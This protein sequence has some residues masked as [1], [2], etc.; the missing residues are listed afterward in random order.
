MVAEIFG[1]RR[2]CGRRR[3]SSRRRGRHALHGHWRRRDRCCAG[4]PGCRGRTHAASD[5]HAAQKDDNRNNG[6]RHEQE[7]Q[8]LPA[9]LNLVELVLDV[10]ERF[11]HVTLDGNTRVPEAGLKGCA[12][13]V[14]GGALRRARRAR[15]ACPRSRSTRSGHRWPRVRARS[16]GGSVLRGIAPGPDTATGRS[17]SGVRPAL[18]CPPFFVEPSST[19]EVKRRQL[20]LVAF[21]GR[22]DRRF[23]A[24]R[25]GQV[26]R[27]L[28]PLEAFRNGR[29]GCVVVLGTTAAR[30]ALTGRLH[31]R[32]A[33]FEHRSQDE[34]R[35]SVGRVPA[36]GFP[37]TNTP[38]QP[39][40]FRA[41]ARSRG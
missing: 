25:P 27:R 16:E 17:I 41:R 15:R 31:A 34:M 5:E 30:F 29:T 19:I 28:D 36:D 22:G 24:L 12:T 9:Q 1:G 35:I 20:T 6:R 40:R 26:D 18:P 39:C 37:G 10:W 14:I 38:R 3:S 2:R 32:A 23:D 11:R 33:R 4:G 13:S 8:L 21:R 7:D